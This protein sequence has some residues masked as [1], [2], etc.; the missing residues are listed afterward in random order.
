MKV[1][2]DP[3]HGMSNSSPDVFDPGAVKK[4]GNDTFAEADVVLRYGLTLKKLFEDGG[5]DVFMTR[6]SSA[7]KAPVGGR[8][9]R[10]VNSGCTLFISL[11]LNSSNNPQANGVEVLFRSDDKDKPLAD[12]L[13]N[14]LIAITGFKDR[15]NK[16]RTDLA[17]LKFSA[18]PGV[19]IELGFISNDA[20]RSFLI[21]GTNRDAICKGIFDIVTGAG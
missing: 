3:G 13:L 18:G 20:D 11:H 14:K 5:I 21:D 1:A 12:L 16:K 4:K 15:G 19:L 17:V 6:S 2:I 9:N 8:A 10:A 7:D